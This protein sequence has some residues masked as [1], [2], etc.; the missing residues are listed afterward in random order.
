MMLFVFQN[1]SLIRKCCDKHGVKSLSLIGDALHD[2]DAQ[3]EAWEY[4]VEFE[5]AENP[6]EAPRYFALLQDLESM[7]ELPVRLTDLGQIANPAVRKNL[8]LRREVLYP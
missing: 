6:T 5:G 1:Q 3:P 4:L 7:T 2:P 8:I